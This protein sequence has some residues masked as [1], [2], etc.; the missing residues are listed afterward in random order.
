MKRLNLINKRFG[1]LIVNKLS[2]IIRFN[3]RCWECICDCGGITYLTSQELVTGNTSSCNCN[4]GI[5]KTKFGRRF[6]AIWKDMIYRCENERCCNYKYYG[7]RGI[8]VCKE[9]ENFKNFYDF[10]VI[11]GYTNL[12]EIDRINVNGNY[13]PSNCKWSTRK[14][15]CRNTRRNRHITFKGKIYTVSQL[16]E[17][18][19]VGKNTLLYQINTDKNLE[20]LY[21]DC[22]N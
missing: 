13:E 14:E 15:Q 21:A 9:W 8:K 16:S 17:L 4:K 22:L 2:N 1:K 6:Y 5:S 19:N 12:L 18:L 3:K 7:K 11:S 10:A 20:L